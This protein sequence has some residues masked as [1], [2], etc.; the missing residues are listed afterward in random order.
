MPGR[1]P[2]HVVDVRK[3]IWL[4]KKT[5]PKLFVM[6]DEEVQPYRKT[7]YKLIIISTLFFVVVE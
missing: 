2:I 7:G 6:Y 3:G 4:L 1:A 5:A